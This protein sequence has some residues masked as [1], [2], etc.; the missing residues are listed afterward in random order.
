[1]ALL[2][3]TTRVATTFHARDGQNVVATLVVA[4]IIHRSHVE[5]PFPLPNGI[6]AGTFDSRINLL[7]AATS[8]SRISRKRFSCTSMRATRSSKS[9]YSCRVGAASAL[10]TVPDKVANLALSLTG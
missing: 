4:R 8:L 5:L 7:K 1:M 3:A 10:A 6:R 2:L 9:S